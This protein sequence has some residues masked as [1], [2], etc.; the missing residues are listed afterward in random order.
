MLDL[1]GEL[2]IGD[3][4]I[5]PRGGMRWTAVGW[6]PKGK[7]VCRSERGTEQSWWWRYRADVAKGWV[8]ERA[9]VTIR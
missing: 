9:G 4:F 3:V 1:G 5:S 7:L 6:S 2:K 8:L